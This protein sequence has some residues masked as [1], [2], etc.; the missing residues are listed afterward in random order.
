[1]SIK[2]CINRIV[3][4]RI[5]VNEEL[6]LERNIIAEGYIDSGVVCINELIKNTEGVLIYSAGIGD[7]INFELDI[8]KALSDMGVNAELYAFDPTPMSLRWLETQNLPNNFHVYP[9]AISDKDAEIEFAL[10]RTD[11]WVSGSAEKVKQDSR[12]FDFK[13]M[14]KVQG[15]CIESIMKELGHTK[16]DLLKMDIEGSEFGVIDSILKT[17]LDIRQMCIDHHE[18][19]FKNGNKYLKK[20]L[21]EL[22]KS[23][24][25]IFY[26]EK[27]SMHNRNFSCIRR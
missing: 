15:R 4:P 16:V 7:Q 14:I 3:N 24:Y 2:E 21:E 27:D 6:E 13:H 8:L 22:K 1:M 26:A 17:N 12:N 11:G 9:Y 25:K 18:Y 19:M 5:W 10:P 20:L 23:E